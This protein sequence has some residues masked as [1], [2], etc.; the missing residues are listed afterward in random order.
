MR[1]RRLASAFAARIHNKV[2]DVNYDSDQNVDLKLCL[3]R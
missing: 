1:M 3:I 2:G